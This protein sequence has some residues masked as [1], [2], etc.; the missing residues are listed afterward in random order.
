MER[1]YSHLKELAQGVSGGNWVFKGAGSVAVTMFSFLFGADNHTILLALLTLIMIDFST[2][3]LASYQTGQPITS[4]RALKT[5]VKITAYGLLASA[6]HLTETIMPAETM[7]DSLVI[8][9]LA[10]TELISILENTGKMG[11]AIPKKL[12]N[13]LEEIRGEK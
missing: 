10:V 1:Y 3:L 6:A 5:A 12:L 4:N 9:F 2:G 7:I 8:S 13:R 11:Y